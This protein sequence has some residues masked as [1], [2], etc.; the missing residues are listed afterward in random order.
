MIW[1]LKKINKGSMP[2]IFIICVAG[3]GWNY[4]RKVSLRW[5]ALKKDLRPTESS[6]QTSSEKVLRAVDV[7]ECRN[8][9]TIKRQ[10]VNVSIGGSSHKRDIYTPLQA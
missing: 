7:S 8:S 2:K 6:S 10:N 9:Q 4:G 5:H 3:E 1:T